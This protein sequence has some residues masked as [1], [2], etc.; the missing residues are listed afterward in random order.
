MEITQFEKE[1]SYISQG[2]DS[3]SGIYVSVGEPRW[4]P[5]ACWCG[6]EFINR[7]EL[8]KP[9]TRRGKAWHGVAQEP[10]PPKKKKTNKLDMNKNHGQETRTMNQH[11]PSVTWTI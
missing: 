3:L 9:L 7:R 10:P 8:K 1:K 5:D 2:F 11:G 4:D 6:E